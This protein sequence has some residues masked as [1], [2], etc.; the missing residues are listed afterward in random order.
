MSKQVSESTQVKA[1]G[2]AHT[3]VILFGGSEGILPLVRGF[4][5]RSI[6]VYIL[7]ERWAEVGYS[8]Y[9]RRI[10]LPQNPPYP[11]SAMDFL[12]SSASD[13]LKDSVLLAGS[14][15]ELEAIARN[16][17]LLAHKFR[18]DLSNPDAQLK[19]LDKLATYHAARD[20][21]VVTPRFWEIRS[22]DDLHRMRDELVYPLILK[23][24]LSHVFQRAFQAKFIVADDFQKLLDGFRVVDETEGMEILLVEHIPGPDSKLASY[25]T[26]LDEEGNNLFDFTKR[27]IRRYPKNMGVGS[28]HITD[29]VQLITEESLK[30]FRHVG[31]L[32][33]ANAEFKYDDRDGQW[34]LI[35]VNARL[36]AANGL[37]AKAG[38]DLGTLVY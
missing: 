34:K 32:G 37:V 3:P 30:L 23:P 29:R 26:Y 6:P 10:H 4:V 25:Y 35:E 24:K 38:F 33:L 5:P 8:R 20:A 18:L 7:N 9:A 15:P 13:Y 2:A 22:E 28:Y 21:G 12:T 11:R 16:R 27:V 36:T 19:M 31:L 1:T 14:D 17:D